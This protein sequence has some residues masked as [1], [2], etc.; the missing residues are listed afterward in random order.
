MVTEE[1]EREATTRGSGTVSA[2]PEEPYEVLM[3]ASPQWKLL[4]RQAS[5]LDEHGEWAL[6]NI[7]IERHSVK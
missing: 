4:K 3:E 6:G 2:N 1:A 5:L 7:A